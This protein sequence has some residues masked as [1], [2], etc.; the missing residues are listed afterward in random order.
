MIGIPDSRRARFTDSAAERPEPPEAHY[1]ADGMAAMRRRGGAAA[2]ARGERGARRAAARGDTRRN[3]GK[4]GL[5][6]SQI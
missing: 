6:E 3:T 4:Y 1:S 5:Q 2:A